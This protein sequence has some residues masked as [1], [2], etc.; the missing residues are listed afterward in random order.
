MLVV[1]VVWAAALVLASTRDA[2]YDTRNAEYEW[3][4]GRT[5]LEPL[6]RNAE[7]WLVRDFFGDQRGGV[8]LD[9]GSYDY[10]R[11]SNTYYLEKE[12]GWSGVAMDAQK[13]FAADYAK[14]RPRTRFFSFFVSDTLGRAPVLLRSRRQPPGGI[15]EQGVLRSLRRVR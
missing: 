12:L 10:K 5:A 4:K 14:Y 6:F 3:F 8:F 1:A 2:E 9:V 15:V 11:F 13:E 7:E